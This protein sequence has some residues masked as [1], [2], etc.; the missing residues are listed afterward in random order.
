MLRYGLEARER[1]GLRT[2]RK[3]QEMTAVARVILER[4]QSILLVVLHVASNGRQH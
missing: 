2:L 4:R 1:T 3:V